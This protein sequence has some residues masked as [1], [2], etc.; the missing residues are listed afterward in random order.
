M[1]MFRYMEQQQTLY[2]IGI[3]SLRQADTSGSMIW[4]SYPL[5]LALLQGFLFIYGFLGHLYH[6][7]FHKTCLKLDLC[8]YV[9]DANSK[10][11]GLSC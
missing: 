6:F 10:F 3:I 8:L 9:E 2:V 5:F 1:D 7:D 11:F 4:E